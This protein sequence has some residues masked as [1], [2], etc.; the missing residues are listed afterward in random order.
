MKFIEETTAIC[1]NCKADKMCKAH[2]VEK[3]WEEFL[4]TF[5]K[6]CWD[7]Y[8]KMVETDADGKVKAG[9]ISDF[10]KNHRQPLLFAGMLIATMIIFNCLYL[11]M[12]MY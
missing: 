7:T 11:M 4:R 8:I 10:L 2:V 12:T 6:E 1:Q 5:C 3:K 9:K